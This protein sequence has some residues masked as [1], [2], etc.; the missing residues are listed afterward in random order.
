MS[1]LQRFL[2]S[3]WAGAFVGINAGSILV[4]SL[5]ALIV[6]LGLSYNLPGFMRLG[7]GRGV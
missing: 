4:A 3:Q 5:I 1:A 6:W 2:L 7:G